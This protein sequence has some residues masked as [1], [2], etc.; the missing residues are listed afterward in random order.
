MSNYKMRQEGKKFIV[1][2][3]LGRLS[4]WMILL[5]YDAVYFRGQTDKELLE[6][7]L[8]EGRIIIT[9][10]TR[11][12]ENRPQKQM[13]LIRSTQF[14]EQVRQVVEAFPMNFRDT[15]LTRCSICSV[16]LEQVDL[17]SMRGEI[18]IKAR[19]QATELF[20][21]PCCGHLYWDGTH[22]IHIMK[23]LKENLGNIF[24]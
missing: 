13:L 7:A 24:E 6:K 9:R 18:P 11:L 4:R 19:E 10:D 8:E 22:P 3:M 12:V 15:I 21:C 2:A 20:R 14:W 5:G 17:E 16:L 1:D 23:Q